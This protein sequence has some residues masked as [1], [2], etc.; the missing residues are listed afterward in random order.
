[1]CVKETVSCNLRCRFKIC[2]FKISLHTLRPDLECD[3]IMS[4]PDA[5]RCQDIVIA[6]REM[7]DLAGYDLDVVGNN[8]HSVHSDATL[9]EIF[10]KKVCICVK[11]LSF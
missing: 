6:L 1:M 2:G 10:G 5:P 9:V 11:C 3:I 7:F 8:R 4:G